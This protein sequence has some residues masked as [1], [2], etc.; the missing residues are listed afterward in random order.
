MGE[1][2]NS[3]RHLDAWYICIHEWSRGDGGLNSLTFVADR[4]EAPGQPRFQFVNFVVFIWLIWGESVGH[5]ET[6]LLICWVFGE[7]SDVKES[8]EG[9]GSGV[10][11]DVMPKHLWNCFQ[12]NVCY[13][14][15]ENPNQTDDNAGVM[16]Y[17]TE[18]SDIDYSLVNA[19]CRAEWRWARFTPT[20]PDKR[21]R[22]TTR[23]ASRKTQVDSFAHY[24]LKKSPEPCLPG[25][26]SLRG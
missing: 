16:M 6:F 1:G 26:P 20:P 11:S 19:S 3:K 9:G 4:F 2:S 23:R 17:Q 21:N 25:A 10:M 5:R 7:H 14:Y 15:R 13:D 22:D 8:A 12:A 24:L 18:P